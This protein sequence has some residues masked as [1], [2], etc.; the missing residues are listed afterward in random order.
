MGQPRP[1]F[2]LFSSFQTNITI[3]TTNKCEKCPSS[4]WR[5][6]L[7]SQPSDYESPPLTTRPGLPPNLT[8]GVSMRLL[9]EHTLT[10]FVRGGYQLCSSAGLQFDCFG[11]DKTAQKVTNYLGYF[12]KKFDHRQSDH[13]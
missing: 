10:Y 13:R 7:K 3:L 9:R 11:D 4:I 6:D 2:R 12:S 5:R 8:V 1:L